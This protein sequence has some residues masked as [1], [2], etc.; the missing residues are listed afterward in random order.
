MKR[1]K[2]QAVFLAAN[3]EALGMVPFFDS[4]PLQYKMLSVVPV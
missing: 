3:L 1:F 2:Q 4:W